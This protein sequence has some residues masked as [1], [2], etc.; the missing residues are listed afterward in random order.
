MFQE[1]SSD[2][3]VDRINVVS[4][5]I[6][7]GSVLPK[8][9]NVSG[10]IN[11]TLPIEVGEGEALPRVYLRNRNDRRTALNIGVGF[12]RIVCM[13]GLIAGDQGYQAR[14]IHRK[15][16]KLDKF[17]HDLDNNLERGFLESLVSFDSFK[18]DLEKVKLTTEQGINI[19]GWLPMSR[20][21]KN[22]AF[23]FWLNNN[24]RRPEDRGYTAWQLYQL[25]NEMDRRYSN[26]TNAVNNREK[27]RVS[28]IYL[29]TG[30]T[31]EELNY[32]S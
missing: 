12:Y 17:I 11:A 22:Q 23:R 24:S 27:T 31:E 21:A 13:N 14:I 4:T 1:I 2:L 16:P 9:S 7:G 10:W 3:I 25:V 6:L 20:R 5:N 19:I 18:S 8:I 28:D 30:N 26:S 32:V 15:G 29:L